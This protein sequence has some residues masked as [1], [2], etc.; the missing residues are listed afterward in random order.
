MAEGSFPSKLPRQ[1]ETNFESANRVELT[2]TLVGKTKLTFN[3]E[4]ISSTSSPFRAFRILLDFRSL[5]HVDHRMEIENV[6]SA[7]KS[8][9]SHTSGP[10]NFF[11]QSLGASPK[12]K[13]EG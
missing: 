5:F 6:R 11:G 1:G 7:S 3:A 13:S 8:F 12:S 2:C 10:E 9:P 4:P